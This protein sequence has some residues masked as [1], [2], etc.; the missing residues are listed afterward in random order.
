[1]NGVGGTTTLVVGAGFKNRENWIVT[2]KIG[3]STTL[4]VSTILVVAFWG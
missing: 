4:V 2:M 1:M 3:R